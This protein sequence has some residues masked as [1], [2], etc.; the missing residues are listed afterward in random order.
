MLDSSEAYHP[1]QMADERSIQSLSFDFGSQT[2]VYKMFRSRFKLFPFSVSNF[3]EEYFDP[4]VNVARS[5]QYFDDFGIA[6]HSPWS[7]PEH[8][9]RLPGNL[10]SR[11]QALNAQMLIWASQDWGFR[12]DHQLSRCQGISPIE[13]EIDS[14]LK[15]QERLTSVEK[16]QPYTG[17]INI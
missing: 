17:F 16:Y 1:L 12:K 5:A 15:N 2:I 3:I 11:S 10:L 6:A 8:R 4:I 9:T 14:L 13:H 7:Y